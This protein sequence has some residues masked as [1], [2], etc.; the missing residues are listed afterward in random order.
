ME[1]NKAKPNGERGCEPQCS[2]GRVVCEGCSSRV[3]M[4]RTTFPPGKTLLSELPSEQPPEL[5]EGSNAADECNWYSD[6]TRNMKLTGPCESS[7]LRSASYSLAVRSP[8]RFFPAELARLMWVYGATPDSHCLTGCSG[9]PDPA[10]QYQ[11]LIDR[12]SKILFG[13]PFSNE[14]L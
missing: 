10:L 4:Q 9:L 8:L 12:E 2:S 7:V 11:F 14:I 3:A 1:G 5:V 6:A 13:S